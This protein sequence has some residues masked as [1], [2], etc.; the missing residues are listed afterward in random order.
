M[1]FTAISP[2]SAR[3]FALGYADVDCVILWS[4]RVR[5]V[6]QNHRYT[7]TRGI[8][9]ENVLPLPISIV[10]ACHHSVRERCVRSRRDAINEQAPFPCG[11]SA[12]IKENRLSRVASLCT[13]VHERG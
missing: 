11:A 13:E 3:S 9:R 2:H 8:V 4:G 10:A 5:Y 6:R 7:I 1:T 12:H